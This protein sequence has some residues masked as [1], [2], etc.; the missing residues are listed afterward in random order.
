MKKN[1]IRQAILEELA[2][3]DQAVQ[4]ALI[5]LYSLQTP[6]ERTYQ[7]DIEKNNVGFCQCDV[8]MLTGLSRVLIEKGSL[9]DEQ[10]KEARRRVMRYGRQLADIRSDRIWVPSI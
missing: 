2:A 3:N 6:D 1:E 8:S 5:Q 4:T 7:C 9:N 10:M